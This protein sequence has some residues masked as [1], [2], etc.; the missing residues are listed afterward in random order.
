MPELGRFSRELRARLWKPSVDDEVRDEMRAHMEQLEESL[1]ARGVP[2]DEAR[3]EA[4]RRFGDATAIAR[5]CRDIGERRDREFRLRR[6]GE[7]LAYDV[8]QALRQLRR[9]PRFAL[10]A[11]ATLAIGLGASTTIFSLANA[12]LFRPLPF[13]R[14]ERLL[15]VN[16]VNPEGI[17]FSVSEP[18]YLDWVSR[19]KSF[20]SWAALTGRSATLTGDG[21]GEPEQVRGV[22][23]THTLFPMLGVAPLRG[24]VFLAEEDRA[25]GDTLVALIS[26]TLWQRRY[27]GDEQVVGRRIEI[28]GVPHRVVGVIPDGKGMPSDADVWTPLSPSPDFPRGDRRLEVFARLRDGVTPEQART[29]LAAVQ[30]ELEARYPLANADWGATVV[31]FRQWFVSP[32]FEQRVLALL[33]TVVLLLVMACTNVGNLLLSRV[34][35]R[36]RELAVRSALGAGSARLARQ[37]LT[38]SIVLAVSGAVVGTV[39]ALLAVPL[40]R[41]VAGESVPRLDTLGV[42]WRVLLF[43]AGAAVVSGFLFGAVPVLRLG[44]SRASVE[45]LRSGTRLAPGGRTRSALIVA[46]VS[47]ATVLLVSASLVG[48]SF[49][50]LMRADLGFDPRGVTIANVS[51]ASD[52]YDSRRSVEF[53]RSMLDGVRATPG[54]EAAAAVVT[55]PFGRGNLSQGFIR[56]E[57]ANPSREGYRLGSWRVVTPGYFDALRIPVVRGRDFTDGDHADADIAVVINETLARQAF[58]DEDPIGRRLA[59]SNGQVKTVIGVVRDTR[60][61]YLDSLPNPTM[62]WAHAQFPWR[63]MWVVVRGS[64]DVIGAVRAQVRALDPLLPVANV[65]P[66]SAL[67]D[68]RTAEARLTMLVFSIFATAALVLAAVGLYGVIAYTVSQRTREIGVTLALGARPALVVRR[69]LGDGMQLSVLGVVVG[70]LFAAWSTSLLRAILYETSP[71]DGATYAGVALLLVVIGGLASAIPARRASRL[72]PVVALREE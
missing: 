38:E 46:S 58:G 3:R 12:V 28:D 7:E 55:P 9:A 19:S 50:A 68:D 14:P 43:A 49:L 21:G 51:T 1:V 59:S 37:L 48:R 18:N 10:A 2:P 11:L 8:R 32:Q 13:E 67:V 62:Y 60:H 4:Q 42:D 45:T 39:I 34:A 66:L 23:A 69:I 53:L 72:D 33:A 64:G 44:R 26:A 47:L 6:Y 63:S 22:M 56:A 27:G 31:P 30:A 36:T 25:G 17:T 57:L 54:V 70:L 29:E 5:E 52:R 61:L 16:E 20:V 24:R 15:I 41:A 71:T 40:L 65:R 35:M